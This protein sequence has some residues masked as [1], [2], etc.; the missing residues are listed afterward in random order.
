M[1]KTL[2]KNVALYEDTRNMR[3][4][5][6][7]EG[8]LLYLDNRRSSL[9]RYKK[10]AETLL[11]E[12]NLKLVVSVAAKKYQNRGMLL[13]DLVQEGNTGLMRAANLFDPEKGFKFSTYA[14][15]WIRQA[16]L[17]GIGNN[18]AIRLP[19][20][21]G[22]K[23]ARLHKAAGLLFQKLGREPTYEEL[24][25]ETGINRWMIH[26]INAATNLTSLDEVITGNDGSSDF[27]HYLASPDETDQDAMQN[28]LNQALSEMLKALSPREQDV[29][30]MRFGIAPYTRTFTLEEIGKKLENVKK[31]SQG[32]TRERVRQM[33][34]KALRKLR[35]S[36]P[37]GTFEVLPMTGEAH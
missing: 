23:A 31:N 9:S 8:A 36:A 10:L 37:N 1:R 17:R 35:K 5:Q 19:V 12:S 4:K 28:I 6:A 33:E 14:T 3:A 22:D 7:A 32:V 25:E 15:W 16:I 26:D 30:K 27:S 34:I 29:M 18:D 21:A 11:T 2:E 20:H 13:M 24:S